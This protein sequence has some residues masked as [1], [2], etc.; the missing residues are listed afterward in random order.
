MNLEALIGLIS[1][2]CAG[3][4]AIAAGVVFHRPLV[5]VACLAPALIGGWFGGLVLADIPGYFILRRADTQ[6]Y[7]FLRQFFGD[8]QG[9]AHLPRWE[10]TRRRITQGSM[11]EARV[12]AYHGACE[13]I[14]DIDCGFPAVMYCI[15][16][17][18][19]EVGKRVSVRVACL[20]SEQPA[21]S[22]LPPVPPTT[23]SNETAARYQ[24]ATAA[25]CSE[26]AYPG[27]VGRVVAERD[28][29]FVASMDS[30]L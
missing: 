14:V 11:H 16:R 29:H 20:D 3:V 21:S 4:M 8:Y 26:R 30:K 28:C 7:L 25:R 18:R 1:S 24:H 5:A 27:K 19:R 6:P 2:L 13:I 15:E 10:E 17:P 22:L 12:L 9:A 23:A